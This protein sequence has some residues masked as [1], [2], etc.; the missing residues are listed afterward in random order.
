MSASSSPSIAQTIDWSR[1]CAQITTTTAILPITPLA[2]T[3]QATEARP[4][5]EGQACPHKRPSVWTLGREGEGPQAGSRVEREGDAKWGQG[6]I[7]SGREGGPTCWPQPE[8]VERLGCGRP[9]EEERV[10]CTASRG[11][12]AEQRADA[13]SRGPQGQ[14]DQCGLYKAMERSLKPWLPPC[15]PEAGQQRREGDFISVDTK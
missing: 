15:H 2:D 14:T 4:G 13:A 6:Q 12:P 5:L 3:G 1:R 8:L 9:L 10:L 11:V 7:S